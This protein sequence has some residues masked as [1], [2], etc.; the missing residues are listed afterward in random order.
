MQDYD[1]I[2]VNIV[3]LSLYTKPYNTNNIVG[4][5]FLKNLILENNKNKTWKK[6]INL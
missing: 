2:S 4:K 6:K 3:F 1:L 5:K